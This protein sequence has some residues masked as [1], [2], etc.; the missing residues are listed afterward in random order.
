MEEHQSCFLV[1]SEG[2]R[3]VHRSH[4]LVALQSGVGIFREESNR[5][6]GRFLEEFPL[7]IVDFWY[8]RTYGTVVQSVDFLESQ[9]FVVLVGF[10]HLADQV[11]GVQIEIFD[12]SGEILDDF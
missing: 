10:F 11:G 2:E 12:A 4:T 9:S 8:G 6:D 7:K 5:N 3:R 1:R